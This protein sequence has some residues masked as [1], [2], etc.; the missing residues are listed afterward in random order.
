LSELASQR[1]ALGAEYGSVTTQTVRE[2]VRQ[3]NGTAFAE[4]LTALSARRAGLDDEE[5]EQLKVLIIREFACA[6]KLSV[7][8]PA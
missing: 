3:S 5:Y 7:S 8:P 4:A 2:F 6:H 1:D